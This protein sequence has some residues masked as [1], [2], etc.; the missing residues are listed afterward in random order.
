MRRARRAGP[1]FIVGVGEYSDGELW[2][3]G[4]GALPCHNKFASFDGNLPHCTLP[5]SGTRWSAPPIAP[6]LSSTFFPLCCHCAWNCGPPVNAA[7]P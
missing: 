1:S 5:F 6:T 2:V 7:L 4:K 3:H